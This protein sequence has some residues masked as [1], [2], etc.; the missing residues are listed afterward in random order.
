MIRGGEVILTAAEIAIGLAGF[1]GIVAA[2]SRMRPEDRVRFLMLVGG[3]FFV[4]VVAFVPFLLELGGLAEPSVWRG[5][6][7]IWLLGFATAL[8]M[9]RAGRKLIIAHGRPAPGWSIALLVLVMVTVALA[10]LGNTLA[11]PFQPG[12]VPFIL[13][14]M[15]GLVASGAIFVYM[16]LIRRDHLEPGAVS[17]EQ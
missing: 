10:Q 2:F 1:S 16:V 4:I 6:S 17:S 3:S 15:M 14:L 7:G 5:S 11:W 13:A 9:I 8:P 12:P